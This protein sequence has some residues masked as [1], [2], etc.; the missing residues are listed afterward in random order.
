MRKFLL[1]LALGLSL[2]ANDITIKDSNYSVN[3]TIDNIKT[4][5]KKKGLG[6]FAIINHKG[7]AKAVGMNMRESK[8]IVFGN[9]KLGTALMKENILSA[10]DLPIKV[11]VY[12]DVDG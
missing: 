8:V 6:V 1:I 2:A 5:V 7:N 11:L 12:E 3:K 4:I 10:L 9:P